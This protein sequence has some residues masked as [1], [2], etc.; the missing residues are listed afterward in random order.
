MLAGFVWGT[1]TFSVGYIVLALVC[2][3]Q[4]RS[5]SPWSRVDV[6]SGGFL[7]L[8]LLATAVDFK[9]GLGR[10]AFRSEDTLREASGLAYDAVTIVLGG[11]VALGDALVFLDYGHWHLVPALEHRGLQGLGLCL[12]G[13][14]AAWLLWADARLAA[15]F[16]S[17]ASARAVIE[18]G[19]FRYVRH[20]RYTGVLAMRV[21]FALA[22]ASAVGWLLALV[23]YALLLRRIGLEERHLVEMFGRDYDAY[24]RR[25]PRL[26]PG[27]Y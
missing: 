16:S 21:A 25:T 2:L 23:W 5:V 4:W 26:I 14:G 8:M 7:G 3:R 18:D 12:E 20:P 10:T 13:A 24:A 1:I 9:F 19:P 17:A 22:L 6:F 27:V 11:L 15:H